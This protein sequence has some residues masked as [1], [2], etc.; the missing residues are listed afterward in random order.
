MGSRVDIYYRKFTADDRLRNVRAMGSV[1]GLP[2]LLASGLAIALFSIVN[3]SMSLPEDEQGPGV[4]RA[5][6]VRR[7]LHSRYTHTSSCACTRSS[8][9][10]VSC[11]TP[12]PSSRS[13]LPPPPPQALPPPCFGCAIT[14]LTAVPSRGTMLRRMPPPPL[15]SPPPPL[16]PP[17]P[18]PPP[19]LPPPPP[20]DAGI[21]VHAGRHGLQHRHRRRWG[22]RCCC[23]RAGRQ[24]ALRTTHL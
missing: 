3:L 6:L 7:R 24:R 12:R 23:G 4:S 5:T 10:A 17:P 16:P 9:C 14:P 18:P 19:P 21:V 22:L 20:P 13:R 1:G 2:E 8:R 11:R 15:L